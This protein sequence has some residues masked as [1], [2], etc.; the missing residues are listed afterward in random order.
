MKSPNGTG[1]NGEPEILFSRLPMQFHSQE[2][3]QL[4]DDV[5]SMLEAPMRHQVILMMTGELSADDRATLQE[6]I[7]RWKPLLYTFLVFDGVTVN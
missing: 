1:E 5:L 3:V 7:D 2:D 6:V 4:L